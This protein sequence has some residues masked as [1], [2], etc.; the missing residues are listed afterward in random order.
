METVFFHNH[1]RDKTFFKNIESTDKIEK[2][3]IITSNKIISDEHVF[4]KFAKK[5]KSYF[6]QDIEWFGIGINEI[7]E[8]WEGIHPF[9]YHIALENK[10]TKLRDIRKTL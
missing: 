6:G 2:I 5:F 7:E 4:F 9:K 8:K 1:E 3:R 10:K